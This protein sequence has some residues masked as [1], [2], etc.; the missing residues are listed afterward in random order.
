MLLGEVS[1]FCLGGWPRP[2]SGF[3]RETEPTEC[4]LYAHN[5]LRETEDER[6]IYFKKLAHA[7]VGAEKSKAAKHVVG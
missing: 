2:L 1:E 4:T 7:V 5:L 3:S 6:Q